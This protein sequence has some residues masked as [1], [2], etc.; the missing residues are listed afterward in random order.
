MNRLLTGPEQDHMLDMISEAMTDEVKSSSSINKVLVVVDSR[1]QW[2][3]YF[4]SDTVVT[5]DDYLQDEQYSST[6]Y[7]VINLCSDLTYLSEGYYCSLL[8]QARKHKVLPSIETLNRLDCNLPSKLDCTLPA[9]CRCFCKSDDE[10][11]RGAYTLDLYF[12]RSEDHS[13][14]KIAKEIFEHYPAPLLRVTLSPK[15]PV[16][17]TS[18][19]FLSLDELDDH[20]QDLF[21]A[22]LDRFSKKVWRN[23]RTKKPARYDLAIFYD[24]KEAL[25]PSNKKALELFVS[26]AKKMG[27]N[28]ELLTEE[29]TGRLLEFDGLF[30][31]QTTSVDNITYKIAQMA[32]QADMVVIDDPSSIIRC[33]NKVY[34]KEYMDKKGFRTPGSRLLFCKNI[35]SY[36][37]ISSVLGSKMVLKI[38]DGSF[39]V[40]IHKVESEPDYLEKTAQLCGRS[41]VLLAQEFMPTDFDWRIGVLNGEAIYACKYYMA[42]GHWQIYNHNG[43]GGG[44]SGRFETFPVHLVPRKITK[45]AEKASLAIGRGLYG[46]DLKETEAGPCLIEINDNPSIDHG[47]EDKVLGSE[48]YRIILR[49][50]VA[51]LDA[52]RTK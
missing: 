4:A 34:L 8:A 26:E 40:G 44:R 13:F 14:T 39:S 47:V 46:V 35:P 25:P 22:N 5:V 31:R 30:I 33:T 52:R 20:Q 45:F 42:R 36:E 24:P 21:A 41:S 28:G 3:P 51:R 50:F 2:A 1:E 7:L 12:G 49:E 15:Q 23:P 27:L 16:Q 11:Q 48:L 18:I 10:R 17:V 9:Q 29:D 43:K 19:S 6:N 32:E 37:E 38:P